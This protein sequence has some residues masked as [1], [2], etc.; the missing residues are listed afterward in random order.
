MMNGGIS[1]G[2][3]H[4]VTRRKFLAAS[5]VI[6]MT[7]SMPQSSTAQVVVPPP[8]VLHSA[9]SGAFFE[10][11]EAQDDGSILFTSY[12][13]K[14]ILRW[15]PSGVTTFATLDVHPVSFVSRAGGGL[16]VVGHGVPFT[17][18]PDFVKSMRLLRIDAIGKIE[19]SAAVPNARFFNGMT[20]LDEATL[21]IA[22][23]LA[24]VI[25]AHRAGTGAVEPYLADPLLAPMPKTAGEF[26][27]GANGI[28][29]HD[30]FLYV[31]NSSTTSIYRVALSVGKPSGPLER[32][33]T[34]NGIDDFA[35]ADDGRLFVAT[36]RNDV[37]MRSPDGSVR[38][39][40][41]QKAEGATAVALGR[42]PSA[43]YLFVTTTGG[44]FAGLKADANLLRLPIPNA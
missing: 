11:L 43:R 41:N 1:K 6:V 15:S 19:A 8:E 7:G 5:G 10:N 9:P 31:S 24:G 29:M 36:H 25:W 16:V 13:A 40:I 12:F 30:G 22:D 27:L 18:G 34:F 32:V 20:R 14:T 33:A 3:W 26:A 38:V 23:S 44:L 37:V 4:A 28:K 42:G 17:S 35:F 39:I 21:L 2:D